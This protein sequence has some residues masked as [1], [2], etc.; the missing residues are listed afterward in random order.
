MKLTGPYHGRR[1]PAV[2]KTF[3]VRELRGQLLMCKWP[4]KRGRPLHPT[5]IE[6]NEKFKQANWA[7]KYIPA[8]IQMAHRQIVEGTNILPRDLMI[9]SMYGRGFYWQQPGQ[10]RRYP[11]AAIH[12]LSDT[13]DILGALAG[14]ILVR[15]TDL[16]EKG[17]PTAPGQ[18][19]MSNA[20]GQPPTWQTIGSQDGLWVQIEDFTLPA[21]LGLNVWHETVIDPG[22]KALEYQVLTAATPSGQEPIIQLNKDTATKYKGSLIYQLSAGNPIGYTYNTSPNFQ[23]IKPADAPLTGINFITLSAVQQQI[24]GFIEVRIVLA[25]SSNHQSIG[26]GIYTGLAGAAVT[27]VRVTSSAGVGLKKNTRILVR[28][29]FP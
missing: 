1:L 24:T 6:Q 14:D 15:G 4:R 7:T 5:T 22:W 23:I 29:I 20:P 19:L 10:N 26:Q 16:W 13:L 28:A 27:N 3:Y 17:R 11:I 21:D 2:G 18:V 25:N 12:D 9:A 8:A